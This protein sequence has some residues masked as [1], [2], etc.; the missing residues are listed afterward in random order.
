VVVLVWMRR[1]AT[2]QPLP[3]FLG[4]GSRTGG[5]TA[6]PARGGVR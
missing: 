3:R 5:R 2:G 6:I 4:A 1:M